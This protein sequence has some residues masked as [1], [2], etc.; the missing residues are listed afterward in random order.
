[1]LGHPLEAAP[2]I[3]SVEMI[4]ERRE[5]F[6]LSSANTDLPVVEKLHEDVVLREH[7]DGDLT[8]EIYVP[9]GTGP[10]PPLVYMHGGAW[11]V[12]HARDLR[13]TAMRIAARGYTVVNLE[14][15]LAPE[16]PFPRAVED[17]VYAARWITQNGER[18]RARSGPVGIGG[19]SAGANLGAAAIVYL[20]GQGG[21][22]DDG[23]LRNVP[24]GF[25]ALLALY[26]CYDFGAEMHA[27]QNSPG[28]TE[29]MCNLAYL[30]P[31]FLAKHA[32]PLVSPARAADLS[33]F[34]PT[35][36]SCGDR[37][38]LL[39]QTLLM[40]RALAEAGVDTTMSI[41]PGGTHEFLVLRESV[42]PGVTEEWERMLDWL[43][44]TLANG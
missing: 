7:E 12:W 22:L 28:S 21:D 37:D 20:T 36:L 17:A 6:D 41:V 8:A 13:Q 29:I 31:H 24:V 15:S 23:D 5:F 38:A 33:V 30:G 14:Y 40:T 18:Y 9:L 4:S 2:P 1:M 27:R 35:Y 32:N 39:P 44:R 34:P 25:G 16:K 42:L 19:D 3:V 26:G 43:D 11:C 10:F